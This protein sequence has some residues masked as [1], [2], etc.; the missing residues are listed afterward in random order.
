[1]G[2]TFI[3]FIF[4]MYSC[5]VM[6]KIPEVSLNG[7][8]VTFDKVKARIS[9]V[10]YGNITLKGYISI[11]RDSLLCFNFNGPLGIKGLSGKFCEQFI[12]KDYYND[13]LYSD[14]LKEL[15]LKSGVIFNKVCIE[16]II[17][18]RLDSLSLQLKKL[19]GNVIE[20]NVEE[21]KKRPSL[22]ISNLVKNNSIKFEFFLKRKIPREINIF[23]NDN[24]ENWEIK[25]EVISISNQEK[26]C[27]FGF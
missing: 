21:L 27:N 1:M 8:Y 10:N 25:I 22:T 24:K 26:K 5:S 9:S 20:V 11:V 15:I 12:V 17:F 3:I 7:K 6:H 16:N 2:R 4:L 13:R 23:Y 18:S 14:V 19:N